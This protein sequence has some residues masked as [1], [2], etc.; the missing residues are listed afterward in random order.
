MKKIYTL[1]SICLF[2]TSALAGPTVKHH[3]PSSDDALR[4]SAT[5][6]QQRSIVRTRAN[7]KH[8][9]DMR[10]AAPVET[11]IITTP[12]AGQKKTYSRDSYSYY[13][14]YM[15]VS[16]NDDKG[17]A[18]DIITT[19][20]GKVYINNLFS[21]I[22][23]AADNWIV[24]TV[25]GDII[26]IHGAQPFGKLT[27]DGEDYLQYLCAV[28][29]VAGDEET[30]EGWFY[31]TDDNTYQLKIEGDKIVSVN[32]DVSLG[33]CE[34][35]ND[36]WMWSGYAEEDV[37]FTPV[38]YEQTPEPDMASETWVCTPADKPAYFTEVITA[39]SDIYIKGLYKECGD[40]WVQG[41]IEGGKAVFPDKQYLGRSSGH[42]TFMT[43]CSIVDKIDEDTGESYKSITELTPDII[44]AYNAEGKTL[45]NDKSL[46]LISK[47]EANPEEFSLLGYVE[48]PLVAYQNR[49]EDTPPAVATG[50]RF[51]PY[52][53]ETDYGV[54]AFDLNNTDTDGNLI[55]DKYLYYEVYMD[56]EPFTFTPEE[57]GGLQTPL[58]KIPFD[59]T[60]DWD[61]MTFEAG[62]REIYIYRDDITEVGI[63]QY[64]INGDKEV[65]GALVTTKDTALSS[66]DAEAL[67]LKTEYFDMNGVA[68]T[69]S[70]PGI[71][72]E[73]RTYSDG[74]VKHFK[75]VKM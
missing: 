44:F 8:G 41:N 5:E 13:P 48:T 15:W 24:G 57:Y 28:E 56:G 40:A 74:T 25:E 27:F 7:Q 38:D 64:Y 61:I 34:Y 66:P 72:V 32:S 18:V 49:N 63:R 9:I 16:Q 75:T 55:D 62:A 70:A 71:K 2:A 53:V 17:V 20:D 52:S 47:P 29:F 22:P 37:V 67:V 26:T 73:R 10:R 6:K 46:L 54:F 4:L 69:A 39:G 31:V 12:P 33:A 11:D 51:I 3:E 58:K 45:T 35:E 60:D 1:S 36:T 68:T 30:G 59:F 42:H 43:G 14:Y 23:D 19:D 65:A 50:L 21:S